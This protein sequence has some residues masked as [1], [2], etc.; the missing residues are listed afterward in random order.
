[1]FCRGIPASGFWPRSNVGAE[2]PKPISLGRLRTSFWPH[3]NVA[4]RGFL[5]FLLRRLSRAGTNPNHPPASAS[6]LHW[7][8]LGPP[9]PA[10]ASSVDLGGQKRPQPREQAPRITPS[11]CRA[12]GV[13][14][15]PGQWRGACSSPSWGSEGKTRSHRPVSPH[16]RWGGRVYTATSPPAVGLRLASQLPALR[17]ATGQ[18]GPGRTSRMCAGVRAG[19]CAGVCVCGRVCRCVCGWGRAR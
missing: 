9:G 16:S 2:R 19:V 13:I 7:Y 8:R 17:R 3:S 4:Q 5:S 12:R 6:A 15:P 10:R 1:M 14:R 18:S 11:R